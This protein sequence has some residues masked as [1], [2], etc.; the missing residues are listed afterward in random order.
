M[1]KIQ[2]LTDR[3]YHEGVEKGNAEGQRLV[4]QA[5]EE[6]AK[7]L[8]EA[9]KEAED[10][11]AGARKEA[12]ELDAHTKSE[13]RLYAGQALNALKSELVN[14]VS[15]RLVKD[16]VKE[17]TDNKDFMGNFMVAVAKNW[18]VEEDIV[19]STAD[20]DALTAYFKVHAKKLLDKGVKIEKVNGKS[21][22]FSVSPTDGSYKVNFGEEEFVAY[23]KG[24]LRPKL[25]EMLF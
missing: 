14:V 21:A 17:L 23:F 5:R 15:D 16:S 4:E 2:E 12:Q 25:V 8:A 9:R 11:M 3:L 1:E 20:A 19:I 10:I 6:A 22:S 7:L 18:A 24:F 13:L